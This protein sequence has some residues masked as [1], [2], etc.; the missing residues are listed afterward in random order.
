MDLPAI[1]PALTHPAVLLAIAI[2]GPILRDLVV[3]SLRE[4]AKR[5][6]SDKDPGNDGVAAALDIAADAVAQA[7]VKIGLPAK[8]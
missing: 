8:K 6:R 2:L 4:G 5:L 7:R 3:A 1:P